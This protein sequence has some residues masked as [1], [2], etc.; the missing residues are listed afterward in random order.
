MSAQL[1]MDFSAASAKPHRAVPR[2]SSWKAYAEY[3]ARY[4][5]C[6]RL[7]L[8]RVWACEWP[9]EPGD[10]AITERM[11]PE[12]RPCPLCELRR[13]L[14]EVITRGLRDEIRCEEDR[15][16]S[17]SYRA[18]LESDARF[19]RTVACIEMGLEPRGGDTAFAMVMLREH[20]SVEAALACLADDAYAMDR[21]FFDAVRVELQLMPVCKRDVEQRHRELWQE[22]SR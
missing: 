14:S 21:E 10:L 18:W 17:L 12:R 16:G 22:V 5:T 6:V 13:A 8:G 1:A 2:A 4:R 7:D 20:G 3:V 15:I 19:M 9:W 11:G